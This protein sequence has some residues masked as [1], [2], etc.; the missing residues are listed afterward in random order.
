VEAYFASI[1]AEVDRAYRVA[2]RARQEGFDPETSPEIPRAQDMAMRVEKLLAHLGVDGISREIRTLAESLPREEVAVRIARR[3]AADTSRGGTVENRVDTALRVG[4]AILTEGILVAPLEGL[5]EVHL[6]ESADGP[7]I[8]LYYAGPIRAAG[9]T[10]QALSV[11]LAD[12]VRRDLGLAAYRPE[13]EEVERYQEEIPLYKYYQHLQYVP[14]A[15]EIA[16]VV[17]HVPVA[18]SGESTEG[19]AEVSAFRNLA[20]VPTNGIRGG[21]CLVIARGSARKRRR[22]GR[23]ST[24]SDWTAGSS[25]PTWATTRPTTRTSRRPSTSRIRS[26]AAPSWPTRVGRAGSGS[27]TAAPGRRAWPPAPSIRR[28]W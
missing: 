21:A 22:S 3:L 13:R 27:S 2:T 26:G 6:R 9:G 17:Q 4:L 14:T 24:S 15:E 16:Q 28:R 25:S 5:A 7:Y 12:I 23:P 19:D 8:E 1:E 11:L 20:R 10:A 18:I